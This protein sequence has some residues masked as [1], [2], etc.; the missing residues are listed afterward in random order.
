MKTPL[1]AILSILFLP[2]A[3]AQLRSKTIQEQSA[4]VSMVRPGGGLSSFFGLLN[5]DNFLMQHTLSYSYL[6]AGGT[7]LSVA[8]YTNSMFYQ[9]ADPLNVRMDITLQGSPFGPTAGAD[10]NSMNKLY[11]SRVEL[12]Y[13]PW[14][15]VL[16]QLQYREMPYF[17]GRDFYD[18]WDFGQPRMGR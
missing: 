14:Q 18:P 9:L 12:N 1:I 8:S 15:D 10:R 4:S 11:L 7:G 13:R 17:S 5:A 6:S 2:A 16:F 3:Q